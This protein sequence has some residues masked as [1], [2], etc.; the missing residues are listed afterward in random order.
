MISASV[1]YDC[2]PVPRILSMK[3]K[4]PAT[5]K[6]ASRRPVIENINI[7][8]IEV[9][10]TPNAL[11]REIPL[12]AKAQR[13][14]GAA[15]RTIAAI[16]DGAD[17][18]KLAIVGPCSIHNLEAGVEYATRLK[19]LA[20]ELD[21]T[22]F[23]VMRVYFEK[24]RSVLGWKGLVNDPYLDDTFRMEDGLRMA[25]GF[26]LR[27]AEFGLPAA[28]EVLDT[29]TPQYL[30]D[31]FAWSAIGARTAESQT[32]REIASGISTPVGFKNA[33]DGSL[34]AA[35]NGIRTAAGEHHFL[36]VT[37]DGLPAIFGTAGN[38]HAHIVLRGGARANYDSASIAECE[39]ALEAAGLPA[40]I[41]VDCSHANSRKKPERQGLV[42]RDLL[43]QI[44]NG[45]RSI[46]GF[47]LESF[48][49][50]GS[51]P[52]PADR[53]RLR[54]GLSVTDPCIDWDTTESLLREAARRLA[55]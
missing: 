47:M 18:R 39:D 36:G 38:P 35:I 45:N 50:W 14:V 20:E 15:R 44:E 3:A 37:G 27:L 48:L 8:S 30:G 11:H 33:T 5:S 9:L 24:P 54:P 4:A 25:R 51:Q 12:S 41:V 6:P 1:P 2:L 31:L 29:L 16:L 52:I 43:S 53:S 49:E 19:R 13:T 42:L 26:L 23:V 55:R 34:E 40:Q 32:H 22:L 10:A 7:K 21:D 17:P 46:R 28:T